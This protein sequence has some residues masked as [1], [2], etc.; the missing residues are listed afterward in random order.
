MRTPLHIITHYVKAKS[1]FC[2][3]FVWCAISAKEKYF[4]KIN[5]FPTNLC[6]K[7]IK[8]ILF[9]TISTCFII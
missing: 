9:I 5:Y 4:N 8:K 6:K 3:G 7:N 1:E 2:M